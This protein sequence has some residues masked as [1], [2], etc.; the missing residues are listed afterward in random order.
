MA[1]SSRMRDISDGKTPTFTF[2]STGAS[3]SSRLSSSRTLQSPHDLHK[4]AVSAA[5]PVSSL[6]LRNY[7]S[8]FKTG[9]YS[10]TPSPG[11]SSLSVNSYR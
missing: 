11:I 7:E 9:R 3:S 10:S 4:N 2:S 1:E 8:K 6:G 5:T